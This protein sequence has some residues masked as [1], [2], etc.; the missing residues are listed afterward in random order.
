[1]RTVALI[2]LLLLPALA[3]EREELM[4]RARELERKAEQLLDRGRRDEALAVLAEAAELR[5][6][7]RGEEGPERKEAPPPPRHDMPREHPRHGVDEA[8]ARMDQAL[9]KGDLAAARAAAEKARRALG[10]WEEALVAREARPGPGA[11]GPAAAP[12][13][14]RL[15]ELERQVA[16]L[17]REMAELSK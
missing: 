14:K 8:L 11:G 1:M 3:G 12:L 2:A 4:D 16:Q 17:R 9:E 15:Q 10:H 6:K 5:A 7:A 13:E